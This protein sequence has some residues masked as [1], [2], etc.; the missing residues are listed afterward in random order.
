MVEKSKKPHNFFL[1]FLLHASLVS[2]FIS[3]GGRIN[4]PLLGWKLLSEQQYILF[5]GHVM[6]VK[7]PINEFK[8]TENSPQMTCYRRCLLVPLSLHIVLEVKSGLRHSCMVNKE[9]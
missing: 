9:T 5:Q 4:C 8:V 6:S 7:S 2:Q 1:S 3:G